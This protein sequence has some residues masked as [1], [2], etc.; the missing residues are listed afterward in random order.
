MPRQP[1]VRLRE[2]L[3]MVQKSEEQHES[4]A[5][6]YS[7]ASCTVVSLAS[8]SLVWSDRSAPRLHQLLAHT[9]MYTTDFITLHAATYHFGLLGGRTFE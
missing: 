6:P 3:F 1:F 4:G 8:T 9:Y 7:D 2:Q 5:A